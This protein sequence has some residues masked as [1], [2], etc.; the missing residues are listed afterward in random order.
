MASRNLTKDFV[1]LRRGEKAN[2]HLNL[3]TGSENSDNGLLGVSVID[4]NGPVT[5]LTT[6]VPSFIC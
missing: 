6:P 3:D 4:Q 5:S 2:Q 1:G